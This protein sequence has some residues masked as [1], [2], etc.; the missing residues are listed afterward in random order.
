L[1]SPKVRRS[2]TMAIATALASMSGSQ[3]T[4]LFWVGKKGLGAD[5]YSFWIDVLLTI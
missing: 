3:W 1:Y 2:K 4:E 5:L